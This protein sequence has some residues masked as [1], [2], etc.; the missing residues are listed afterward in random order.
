MTLND[1]PWLSRGVVLQGYVRPLATLKIEASS[2]PTAVTLLKA[3]NNY[4]PAERAAIRAYGADTIRFQISQPALNP[5]NTTMY[6]PDYFN[7][8]VSAIK[9]ARQEGFIVMIMM[10]DEPITG[11]TSEDPLPTAETQGDWDLFT[12]V[13]GS[14]R[15]VVFELYNEPTLLGSATNWQLWLNGGTVAAGGQTYTA[16]GMQPLISHLRNNG[17]QNVFVLDALADN[18]TDPVTGMTV[19]EAAATL[20]GM[21]APTDPL[22]RLVYAVHPYQHGLTVESQWDA[23]FGIPSQSVPVWAD[24]WSAPEGM[25]LG[26]GSMTDTQ[27]AVDLL[28]YLNAHSIPLCTGAFDVPKFVVQNLNPWTLTDYDPATPMKS[29]GR[30]VYND[31]AAD[32]SRELTVADGL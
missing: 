21:Q 19:K 22:N 8:V 32:Y 6:D 16:I 28:N 31:F 1:R 2:D 3:R 30:L 10:Q 18:V 15:G 5:S 13:F 26:L 25:S 7:D 27:V 29:S 4:T 24:E 11:D 17:A 12:P 23:E 14:D 9:T 20:D